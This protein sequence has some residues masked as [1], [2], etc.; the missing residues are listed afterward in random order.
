MGGATRSRLRS[1]LVVTQLSLSV[2]LLVLAGLLLRC[3]RELRAADTGVV[4]ERMIAAE[5]D[6]TTLGLQREQGQLL[7]D[8]VVER[9]RSMPDVEGAALSAWFLTRGGAMPSVESPFPGMLN[10]ARKPST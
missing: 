4:E 10:T 7:F 6:L 2:L 5:F 3:L 8:R 9:V 1:T